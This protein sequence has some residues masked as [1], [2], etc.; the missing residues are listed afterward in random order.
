MKVAVVGGGIAGLSAAYELHKAASEFRLFDSSARL[1]GVIRTE[2]VGDFLMEAGP[3]SWLSE[4][5]AAREL[6]AELGLEKD[7]IGSNDARHEIA[8]AADDLPGAQ[9]LFSRLVHGAADQLGFVVGSTVE[10]ALG[11]F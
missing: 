3:D 8:Q 2:Q 1:G 9:G 10:Q 7:L 11:S 4:K 5:T 6:C